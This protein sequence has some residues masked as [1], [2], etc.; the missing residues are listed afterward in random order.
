MPYY[1][2]IIEEFGNISVPAAGTSV[3]ETLTFS[4]TE[5][6]G[7]SVNW[8]G[9]IPNAV[10]YALSGTD[11]SSFNINSSSGAITWAINNPDD[12]K[13]FVFVVEGTDT[14]GNTVYQGVILSTYTYNAGQITGL[15]I[16]HEIGTE[17][18]AVTFPAEY[19]D[20][21]VTPAPPAYPAHTA[22]LKDYGGVFR[23]QQYVP[24]AYSNDS[25][26]FMNVDQ[27]VSVD[28]S[29]TG[30]TTA[31]DRYVYYDDDLTQADEAGFVRWL[32]VR[33]DTLGFDIDGRPDWYSQPN[34]YYTSQ[35]TSTGKNPALLTIEREETITV[36]FDSFSPNILEN[37]PFIDEDIV[38]QLIKRNGSGTVISTTTCDKNNLSNISVSATYPDTI[39]IHVE[40]NYTRLLF[41]NE[42]W[43]YYFDK[44]E[45]YTV[46]PQH[47]SIDFPNE[48]KR[49]N[50]SSILNAEGELP[51]FVT[52]TQFEN[53]ILNLDASTVEIKAQ[54]EESIIII[55]PQDADDKFDAYRIRQGNSSQT[56]INGNVLDLSLE[57]PSDAFILRYLQDPVTNR[58]ITYTFTVTSSIPAWNSSPWT[59]GSYTVGSYVTSGGNLYRVVVAGASDTAP[60]GTGNFQGTSG[61]PPVAT[62]AVFRY[63]PDMGGTEYGAATVQ[64]RQNVI[65]NYLS[66]AERYGTIIAALP[67][68]R[69][70]KSITL[71]EPGRQDGF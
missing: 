39:T 22:A 9:S 56:A 50:N 65:N 33:F 13:T 34:D 47:L 44:N 6:I 71:A 14:E 70:A 37:T 48:Q 57:F 45:D 49:F 32:D 54:F 38:V 63:V 26:T 66:G 59:I 67:S 53:A 5:S 4:G 27:F 16:K 10:S 17:D 29:I 64:I 21:T 7:D 51:T 68:R 18:A 46:I 35:G 25:E 3:A 40:G 20:P 55:K 23:V 2:S 19:V 31:T 41:P 12:E 36:T 42:E 1:P 62:G 15:F 8:S 30:Y 61:E 52:D 58:D 69:E 43:D 28:F 60:T 11:A 24:N